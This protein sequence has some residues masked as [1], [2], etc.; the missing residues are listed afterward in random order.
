M[1][2]S[3]ITPLPNNTLFIQ[4][5]WSDLI[6]LPPYIQN[7]SDCLACDDIAALSAVVTTLSNTISAC[8]DITIDDF[9]TLSASVTS[10]A[11]TITAVQ[12][13]IGSILNQLN[14]KVSLN[15]FNKHHHD[16]RYFTKNQLKYPNTGGEVNWFNITSLTPAMSAVYYSDLDKDF[17][18][19]ITT[20]INIL[21]TPASST[22]PF[23]TEFDLNARVNSITAS[24]TAIAVFDVPTSNSPASKF[25]GRISENAYDIYYTNSV[26]IK[27]KTLDWSP[28]K[29][30]LE[31]FVHRRNPYYEVLS[32]TDD[33]QVAWVDEDIAGKKIWIGERHI[34]TGGLDGVQQQSGQ[35]SS[36]R[37]ISASSDVIGLP[38]QSDLYEND[39]GAR[40]ANRQVIIYGGVEVGRNI[41]MVPPPG[42][43][44]FSPPS[45]SGQ[46][47]YAPGAEATFNKVNI[48]GSITVTGS[49]INNTNNFYIDSTTGTITS[50][51]DI[52]IQGDLVARNT[53]KL[54][55]NTGTSTY[56]DVTSTKIEGTQTEFIIDGF[57]V[58]NGDVTISGSVVIADN[59]QVE[60]SGGTNYIGDDTHIEGQFSTSGKIEIGGAGQTSTFESGIR[61]D[62]VGYFLGDIT[63]AFNATGY[64]GFFGGDVLISGGLTIQD[65]FELYDDLIINGDLSVAGTSTLTDSVSAATKLNSKFIIG[66]PNGAIRAG[67]A[68]IVNWTSAVSRSNSNNLKV[69]AFKVF[70]RE[71]GSS[72]NLL[73]LR[74]AEDNIFNSG[75][76]V[77]PSGVAQNRTTNNY[78]NS[79]ST[80]NGVDIRAPARPNEV[81]L[82]DGTWSGLEIKSYLNAEDA[83]VANSQYLL[84]TSNSKA[85][86]KTPAFADDFPN[87]SENYGWI[88][89]DWFRTATEQANNVKFPL[90]LIAS[91]NYVDYRL[92]QLNVAG[93]TFKVDPQNI[94]YGG[95]NQPDTND[96][97]FFNGSS[98]EVGKFNINSL[99]WEVEYL[100]VNGDTTLGEDVSGTPRF[101]SGNI[102]YVLTD[103][104]VDSGFTVFLPSLQASDVGKEMVIKFLDIP[105]TAYPLKINAYGGDTIDGQSQYYN[106]SVPK[107]A[108]RL[109]VSQN[110][111]W[112]IV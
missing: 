52:I 68:Y 35:F 97:I 58:D 29:Y 81:Y 10:N 28:I 61:A 96:I 42:G 8:E 26:P 1:S 4:I 111:S 91:K 38:Q 73:T 67:D 53:F 55:N 50:S 95:P 36:G 90:H 34:F 92:Q 65:Y 22:N 59:L 16:C 78:I 7:L 24:E 25:V 33:S 14:T 48:N 94:G 43:P 47:L 104:G 56:L 64:K 41:L 80:W 2:G 88:M 100:G 71:F 107:S 76:T 63:G 72:A 3:T 15:V 11:A 40:F 112:I 37:A 99:L 45:T 39:S 6:N 66:Q 54:Y 70:T 5:D 74:M 109:F 108:I 20:Q 57:E 102:I 19:A 23:V 30:H 77:G 62:G 86:S 32:A 46:F 69:S 31:Y 106:V 87:S 82:D 51:G 110:N 18:D 17:L 98:W 83:Q 21:G 103:E 89:S 84:F 60:G 27:P 101:T 79:Y 49:I 93:S 75:Y 9:N 44:A 13:Q 85:F 12:G 105:A